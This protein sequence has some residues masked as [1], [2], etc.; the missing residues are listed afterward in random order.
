MVAKFSR[1]AA[2]NP[3]EEKAG[4]LGDAPSTI[5]SWHMGEALAIDVAVTAVL[6]P[7][8]L[9]LE[10]PA[11]DYAVNQKHKKYD[12]SF[13]NTSHEFCAMVW[14]DFGAITKEGEE[15]IKDLVKMGADRL[16]YK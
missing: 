11:E 14:E 12:K 8:N 4:I 7:K 3:I 13:E 5:P 16:G 1:N 10:S 15:V 6:Q 2:L 9:S